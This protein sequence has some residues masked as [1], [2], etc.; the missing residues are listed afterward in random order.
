MVTVILTLVLIK[1]EIE[2]META[3]KMMKM[4]VK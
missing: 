4:I 3:K 2:A 1:I